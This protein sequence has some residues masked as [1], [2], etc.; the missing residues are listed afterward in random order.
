[1]VR[2]CASVHLREIVQN[3]SVKV[4]ILGIRKRSLGKNVIA[5]LLSV[6]FS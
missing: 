2:V 1:V 3:C 5:P 6:V 4:G